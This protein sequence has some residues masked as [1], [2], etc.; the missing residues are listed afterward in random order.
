[1]SLRKTFTDAELER[2]KAAVRQAEATISGEIV[3]VMVS[4]SGY[5]TIANYKGSLWVGFMVF[6][7]IVVCD[8][9]IPSLAV[10]DPLLIFLLVLLAGVVGGVAPNF[11][12]DLRRMLVTQR[13][14][15]HATR[16]RAENAF[17]EQEVF[18]TRHRTGIMIFISFFEHEVI[19]MGDQG[20]SK[21]VEQ[22]VWDRL[23]QDLTAQIRKGKTVE[24]L[25]TTIKRCGEILLEK[26]FKKTADDVNEL[27]DDVRL[28]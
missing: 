3:P 8:R 24:G 26:G 13:H 9:F 5:Y 6:A 20:I 4:K 23:V 10:Y 28:D 22:K 25:E 2:I 12:D 27:R 14:M 16:Q 17:L 18:N 11:S 1:M 21:V 19:I 7:F 15:D